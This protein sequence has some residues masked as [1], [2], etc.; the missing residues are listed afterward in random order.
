MN[1]IN[2]FMTENKT[3]IAAT[4][5]ENIIKRANIILDLDKKPSPQVLYNQR[6]KK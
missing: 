1:I 4:Q 6:V 5:D 3:I 2:K